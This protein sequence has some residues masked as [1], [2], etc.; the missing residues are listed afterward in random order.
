MAFRDYFLVKKLLRFLTEFH[1]ITEKERE[2]MFWDLYGDVKK[3]QK[4]GEQIIVLLD[5]AE[6]AE[7]ANMIG[8]L[9]KAYTEMRINSAT[10]LEYSFTVSNL[11]VAHI[12]YLPTYTQDQQ[13]KYYSRAL[14]SMG[15]LI[16]TSGA[17]N[18]G[19]NEID[20]FMISGRGKQLVELLEL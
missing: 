2:N 10:F 3:Q 4:I 13:G 1:S 16:Q 7:K 19:D 20:G 8:K 11:I 12:K 9:F 17:S 5:K 18:S 14:H 15:L 6:D